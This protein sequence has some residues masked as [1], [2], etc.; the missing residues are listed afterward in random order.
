MPVFEENVSPAFYEVSRDQFAFCL[1]KC[2]FNPRN[3]NDMKTINQLFSSYDYYCRDRID[4][5]LVSKNL[6]EFHEY[7]KR[8][9]FNVKHLTPRSRMKS[10]IKRSVIF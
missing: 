5:D 7:H 2:G 1:F 3:S 8:V 9:V 10:K 4:V 6:F